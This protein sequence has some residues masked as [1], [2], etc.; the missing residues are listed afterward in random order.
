MNIIDKETEIKIHGYD[1][2]GDILIPSPSIIDFATF[3]EDLEIEKRKYYLGPSTKQEVLT[4][5]QA[6]FNRHFNLHKVP[7]KGDTRCKIDK[8]IL[9]YVPGIE[10]PLKIHNISRHIHPFNLPVRFTSSSL[11]EC[12][13]VENVTY[14]NV[15]EFL[16]KMK[17][18]FKEIIL[19]PTINEL[20]ESSYVHEITHTQLAHQRGIIRNYYNSEIPS[21]FME[22]LN[23]HESPK[24]DTLL[25]LQDAIRMTELYN[26]LY[27]L[28]LVHKNIQEEPYDDLIDATKYTE[29]IIKAYGLFVEYYYGTPALKKYILTCIQNMLD[30][31]LELEELLDEFEI[32]V[33]SSINNPK[34]TRYFLR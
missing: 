9:R 16:K 20:T 14:I 26:L 33:E 2:P 21:I 23:V 27:R 15:E 10:L 31:N 22:L 19:P 12:M 7:Y 5:A 32:T 30:G 11:V 24:Q 18:S 13:V 8:Y 1:K 28:E 34:L 6:F 29:S 3:L 4:N 25:P 17:L